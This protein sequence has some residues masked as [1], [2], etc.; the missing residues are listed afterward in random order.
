MD[1]IVELKN[2]TFSAQEG[3]I[4]Q[5]VTVEFAAGK[6]TAIVGPSGCGKTSSA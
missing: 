3:T 2:V 1:N 5:G 4:V 6:T